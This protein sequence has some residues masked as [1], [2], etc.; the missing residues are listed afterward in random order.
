MLAGK[1]Y[2]YPRLPLRADPVHPPRCAIA[3]LRI[4]QRRV[5]GQLPRHLLALLQPQLLGHDDAPTVEHVPQALG[6][7]HRV[8]DLLEVEEDGLQC[9]IT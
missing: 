7:E 3:Q 2:A 9:H 6:G 4:R 5:D 1:G 8:G